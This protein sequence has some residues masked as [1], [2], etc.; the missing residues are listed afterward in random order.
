MSNLYIKLYRRYVS[1]GKK[2]GV[3]RAQYYLRFQVSGGL[4][5]YPLWF[6][7]DCCS[8]TV[9]LTIVEGAQG[10]PADPLGLAPCFAFFK[11]DSLNP[12]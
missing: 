10:H 7:R 12:G 3:S 6:R 1:L 9:M 4:G 11:T 5:T 8:N 2:H